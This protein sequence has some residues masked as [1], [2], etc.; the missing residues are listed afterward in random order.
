MK[1]IL[2][3]GGTHGNFLSRCLSISSNTEQ[4]FDFYGDY[5]GAHASK[6]FKKIVDHVHFSN[7]KNVWS[8]IH[9][10]QTDLYVTMWHTY[11]AAGEFGL[12]LLTVKTFEDLEP[13][14]NKKTH[15]I[16]VNGFDKEVDIFE[17]DG[18]AGL[19]EMFKLSFGY[20][21]GFLTTQNH[22]YN[23][24]TIENKFR[25]HWF[26]NWTIF[27]NRLEYLLDTLGLKYTVD[28]EH[29]WRQFMQNKNLILESKRRVEQAYQCFV[30]EQ[31]LDISSF[32]IYEQAYLDHLVE[33]YLGYEIEIWHSGYPNNMQD[34][35]P[36]KANHDVVTC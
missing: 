3:Q 13:F 4:D 22:I 24:H 5:R 19:R 34:Y 14:L 20:K 6:D 28:I 30:L 36:R 2:F 18:V 9:L 29:R 10:D 16:V 27:K 21:N 35:T 25:V 31:A 23:K 7:N 33:T 12:D 26:Y 11:H 32:C 17:H 8:Y 1:Q 15:P